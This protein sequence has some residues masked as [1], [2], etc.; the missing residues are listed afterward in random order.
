MA[1]RWKI[2]SSLNFQCY[3][4]EDSCVV[5]SEIAGE[6]FFLNDIG[7]LIFQYLMKNDTRFVTEVELYEQI[8]HSQLYCDDKNSES[9]SI[10]ILLQEL[11]KRQLVCQ[12]SIE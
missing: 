12:Q 1:F 9:G 8:A 5:F 10:Q 3:I 11:T 2:K 7:Y 4:Q 6:L